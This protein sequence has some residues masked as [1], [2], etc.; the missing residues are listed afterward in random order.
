MRI[1]FIMHLNHRNWRKVSNSIALMLSV[2]ALSFAGGKGQGNFPKDFPL[3]TFAYSLTHSDSISQPA[4]TTSNEATNVR[5]RTAIIY[6]CIMPGSG[7]SMLGH[8]AKG[9]SFSLL[10]FGSALTTLIS[11]NNYVARGERLDALEFQYANAT[12]WTT[13][14]AIYNSM[15]DAHKLLNSDRKRRNLFVIITGII[16]SANIVDIVY[17]TDDQGGN[18]FS[19]QHESEAP[20]MAG[21]ERP[22]Q[23]LVQL[24]IPLGD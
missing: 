19:R 14:N 11:H 6:S 21:V 17:F 15:K 12:N 13:A 3:N 5:M 20:L 1:F 22:H 8:T 23:T 10:A 18:I 7:Q 24:S 4:S 16:W 9:V 2:A